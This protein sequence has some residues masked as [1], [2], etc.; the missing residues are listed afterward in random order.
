MFVQ[1]V[2]FYYNKV[3]ESSKAGYSSKLES[4]GRMYAVCSRLFGI[5]RDDIDG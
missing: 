1:I 2:K 4:D 3:K 5:A